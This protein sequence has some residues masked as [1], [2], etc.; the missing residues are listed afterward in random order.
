MAA[1]L[2]FEILE[3]TVKL[4]YAETINPRKVCALAKHLGSPVEYVRLDL[5][6]GMHKAPD[7]L[8]RNPNGLV[9]VLV[10]GG[11]SLWE[12]NAIL[13][14]L[15]GKAGS[16]MWPLRDHEK[17]AD[18]LRWLAWETSSWAPNV[19]SYYFEH[20][21]RAS[22]GLGDPDLE[23]LA[24]KERTFHRFAKVLDG[25][26]SAHRFLAGNTMTVA[27]FSVGGVMPWADQSRLP[28][29]DYR[30]IA[31]WHGE[32]MELDAWRS[33]WPSEA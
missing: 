24:K 29:G 15:A 5:S 26:L 19:G 2:C 11:R 18:I 3:V 20:V 4:Y 17:Q 33:P 7:H 25:H 28:L 27:D 1:R 22:F 23:Q 14:Y 8:A 21:I 32:L 16:E 10:D 31:R 9:P 13:A 12:S 6:Q 30:A